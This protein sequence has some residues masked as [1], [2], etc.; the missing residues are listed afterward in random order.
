MDY[1]NGNNDDDDDFKDDTSNGNDNDDND[2]EG[3][4]EANARPQNTN[5][6][7][8]CLLTGVV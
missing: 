3:L 5:L 8:V 7:W 4:R 2:D 1:D 6:R